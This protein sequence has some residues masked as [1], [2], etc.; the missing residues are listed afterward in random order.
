MLTKSGPSGPDVTDASPA[1]DVTSIIMLLLF[2]L[3]LASLMWLCCC[4]WKI[5][6]PMTDTWRTKPIGDPL[7]FGTGFETR[8]KSASSQSTISTRDSQEPRR[9]SFV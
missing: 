3:L 4:G 9:I 6:G 2:I 7:G 8:L 5:E 1:I